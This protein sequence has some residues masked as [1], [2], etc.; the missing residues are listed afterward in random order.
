MLRR[1]ADAI[2][3]LVHAKPHDCKLALAGLQVT[4]SQAL[5]LLCCRETGTAGLEHQQ[6]LLLWTIMRGG[7]PAKAL[8]NLVEGLGGV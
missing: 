2:W 3:Y 1:K 5:Q 4:G 6:G 8:D 7:L